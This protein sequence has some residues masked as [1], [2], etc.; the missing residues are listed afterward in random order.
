M[1]NEWIDNVKSLPNNK[2]AG[3]SGIS[4]EMLKNL[5]EDNQSFLHAFIC[6][7]MDLNNIPDKWKKAMIYP[8]SLT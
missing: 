3:P 7:C 6:V 4:Y 5:N 2:A 1:L 8:S